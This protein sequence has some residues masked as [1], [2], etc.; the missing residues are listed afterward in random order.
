MAPVHQALRLPVRGVTWVPDEDTSGDCERVGADDWR[1]APSRPVDLFVHTDGPSGS[2]RYWVLT[3]GTGPKAAE[4]PTRGLC[5]TTS[6][7]G[8]RTLRRFGDGPLPWS[9]DA[10]RDG[11][12]E[13]IVWSSFPLTDSASNAEFGLVAWVYEMRSAGVLGIDWALSRR[14]ARQIATAYR[15]TAGLDADLVAL[16]RRAAASLTAFAGGSCRIQQ[17]P[18]RR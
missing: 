15:D 14:M 10:D 9:G 5:L 8:W 16:R 17:A 13:V 18:V 4:A 2:G 3:L 1:L 6:T 7:V 11:L 12:G